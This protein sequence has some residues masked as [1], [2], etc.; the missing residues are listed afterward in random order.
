MRAVSNNIESVSN[1]HYVTTR[2][3]QQPVREVNSETK[4]TVE[5]AETVFKQEEEEVKEEKR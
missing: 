1:R 5:T 3:L 4:N 2:S